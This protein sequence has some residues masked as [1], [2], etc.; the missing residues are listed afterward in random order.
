MTDFKGGI[1]LLRKVLCAVLSILMITSM[2]GITSHATDNIEN[3]IDFVSGFN[4]INGDPDGNFRLDDFVT[5]AEFTK[6]AVMASSLRDSVAPNISVS[7]F[8]DVPY[9]HWAAPYVKLAVSNSVVNGYEDG[10]FRPDNLVVYEEG[11]TMFLKLLGYT[12]SDFGSSWPY[13]QIAIAK[14]K[15]ITQ[16]ISKNA[17][18]ALTRRD[19]IIMTY[20]LLNSKKKDG[21]TKYI[22]EF[23]SNIVEDVVLLSTPNEDTSVGA[24]K[25]ATTSGTY[26]IGYNYTLS[27]LG[28]KGDIVVRDNDTIISFI[29][30]NQIIEEY[31]VTSVMGKDLI[32]NEK[33]LDISED[34]TSYH[35]TKTH[36]YQSV[37]A[38]AKRGDTFKVYKNEN[39]IIDY[40]V[41]VSKNNTTEFGT[42]DLSRYIVYSVLNNKVLAYKDGFVEQID[43]TNSVTVYED[44]NKQT[45]YSSIKQNMQ[46]GDILNVKY[47]KYGDIEY[48]VYEDGNLRGPVTVYGNWYARYE[49]NPSGVKV[50]K[51]G[52]QSDFSSLNNF[53]V[54]YYSEE[55]GMIFAYSKKAVGVYESAYPNKDSLTSVTVSGVTYSIESAQAFNKLSS[56]GNFNYG[57]TVT[58]LLGKNGE[59]ADVVS[60]DELSVTI[61]GYLTKTGKK[62]YQDANG[63]NYTSYYAC[64]VGADGVL[65]E[66]KVD[67]DYEDYINKV[68]LLT[69]NKNLGKLTVLKSKNDIWGTVDY[70]SMKIGSKKLSDD[71]CI[72]E[73]YSTNLSDIT[74]Y[75]KTYVQRLNGLTI[76]S[77]DVYYSEYNKNG[78]ISKLIIKDIT[79]D[80]H[81]YGIVTDINVPESGVSASYTFTTREGNITSNGVRYNGISKN[82]IVKIH[83]DNSSKT[84]E[85]VFN[86]TLIDNISDI[87]QAYAKDKNGKQYA[88]SPEVAVFKRTSSVYNSPFEIAPLSDVV[89]GDYSID[90]YIDKAPE[91]GGRVRVIC[92]TAKN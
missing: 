39:G 79:G 85:G 7:P 49:I 18:D 32:L 91:K 81:T 23:D 42:V 88:L 84:A 4:I 70:S 54:A 48:V 36:S 82:S 83:T 89:G 77:S 58:L 64:I 14:N 66:Y 87:N 29:P 12:N 35:K 38:Q 28:K 60:E 44:G 33:V 5:R 62:T 50:V 37:T 15:G 56:S 69:Y 73:I 1:K 61:S 52:K 3:Y 46:M 86:L 20:N 65:G 59:I 76:G 78:E 74:N 34:T 11:L 57:D 19:C 16:N 30:K 90:V 53:D 2:F 26:K 27:D 24:G 45:S 47:D 8:N 43:I 31:E 17:G 68:V 6:I 40:T 10:S 51:D 21:N 92:A 67:T 71:V 80:M 41:L 63:S 55:M 72:L 9:T 75:N 13:S 22:A 25:I